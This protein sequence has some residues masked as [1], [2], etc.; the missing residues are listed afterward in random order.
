MLKEVFLIRCSSAEGIW[1]Y[2]FLVCKFVGPQRTTEEESSSAGSV[3]ETPILRR[4][5]TRPR[6]SKLPREINLATL[7]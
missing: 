5:L 1:A 7:P 4:I 6:R 3:V 2:T